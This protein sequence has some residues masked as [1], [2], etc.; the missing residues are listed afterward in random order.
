MR[1]LNYFSSN[2]CSLQ[3]QDGSTKFMKVRDAE[4]LIEEYERERKERKVL[5]ILRKVKFIG[6]YKKQLRKT[7][8]KSAA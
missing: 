5:E 4:K 1:I 6:L 7:V 2:V 8:V 3:C